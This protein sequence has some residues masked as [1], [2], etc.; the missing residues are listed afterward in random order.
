MCLALAYVLITI[1]ISDA[2]KR[3]VHSMNKIYI[4]SIKVR[5]FFNDNG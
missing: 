1:I 5:L 4:I 2:H 3:T